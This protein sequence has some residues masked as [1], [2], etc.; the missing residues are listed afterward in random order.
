M[1]LCRRPRRQRV[2][3]QLLRRQ[4]AAPADS[5]GR[6]IGAHDCVHKV[7]HV[8]SGAGI[9]EAGRVRWLRGG[10][11]TQVARACK[12]ACIAQH[13]AQT[14][15]SDRS[16]T[17]CAQDVIA[18]GRCKHVCM[19]GR[20]LHLPM[21]PISSLCTKPAHQAVKR[22]TGVRDTAGGNRAA[23]VSTL[24]ASLPVTD[25]RCSPLTALSSAV[26]A[27]LPLA[28]LA[29]LLVSLPRRLRGRRAASPVATGPA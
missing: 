22:S 21:A 11:V 26:L 16:G 7:V 15:E 9:G 27:A 3:A 5:A 29:L 23:P 1:R 14:R 10:A 20:T 2:G 13:R 17:A 12:A 25:D 28:P 19:G 8:G 18:G 24:V 6:R 4:T